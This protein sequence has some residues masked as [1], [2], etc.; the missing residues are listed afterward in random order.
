MRLFVSAIAAAAL[1]A[2]FVHFALQPI[3]DALS[4]PFLSPAEK[5][6]VGEWRAQM[7]GGVNVTTIHADHT[8]SSVGGSC[9]GD[10]DD[11]PIV[12]HWRIDGS[13][14]VLQADQY[15]FSDDFHPDPRRVAIQKWIDSDRE[16]R[17]Q[18][19]QDK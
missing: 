14:V 12:G 8:W 1:A 9:F 15:Q 16:V 6:V 5:K 2:A 11:R 7:I 19:S 17:S 18:A 10:E 3:L 4:F 13:D